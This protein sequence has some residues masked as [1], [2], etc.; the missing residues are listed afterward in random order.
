MRKWYKILPDRERE[1]TRAILSTYTTRVCHLKILHQQ[2]SE[3][4]HFLRGSH[5]NA[6]MMLHKDRALI[7]R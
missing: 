6:Q 3:P 5:H 1:S 7:C 4:M 2:G